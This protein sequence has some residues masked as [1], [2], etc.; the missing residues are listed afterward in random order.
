ME[1]PRSRQTNWLQILIV[2]LLILGVF[3]RFA[4]LDY[5]VYWHDEVYTSIRAAGYTR[6]EIDRELFQNRII[7]AK[8]LQKFQRLKPG[9]TTTDTI[10]S[11]ATED[12]QHP[13]LYFLM[14][15]FWMQLFGSSLTA[16]RSLP[17]LLSL[18]GLPLMYG[19]GLELF[20]SRLVAIL[21]TTLL[22]LSPFDILFAQTARQYSLLTVTVIGS[23]FLL[24]RALRLQTWQNWVLY[25]FCS[26][27]GLYTHPI[28]G[29]TLIAQGAYVLVLSLPFSF[30][31]SW[32]KSLLPHPSPLLTKAPVAKGRKL[33]PPLLRGVRGV[34]QA[35]SFP[36]SEILKLN[37]F[38]R[39]SD[40]FWY[41]LLATIGTLFLYSP[42][43][44][45]IT[46][47][48]QRLSATTNW[49]KVSPGR[50]HLIKLWILNFTSLF[51]DLDFGLESIWSYL[52]RLPV[53]ILIVVAIYTV[54]RQT[55][56][57]IGLFILTAIFVPFLIL[58]L[59]DVLFGGKRS[60]I[61]RYLMSCYPG[62]Q[63]VVAYLLANKLLLEQWLWRG[64]AVVLITGSI[65]S[66]TVSGFSD[67]WWS[68]GLSYFNA[69][70]ARIINRDEMNAIQANPPLVLS[71]IGDDFT[72]TGDLISLSYLLHDNV[73]LLLLNNP[74][75]L[76]ILPSYSKSFVF[77]PSKQLCQALEDKQVSLEQ[78]SILGRL[79]RIQPK[80][81]GRSPT[82]QLLKCS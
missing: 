3:F 27:V 36:K 53:F 74:P 82:N 23:N 37:N 34:L 42:W 69:E 63:L 18:L 75:N 13:P 79:W 11:L 10:S 52:L 31:S 32:S 44:I 7:P 81:S 76:E 49:T 15:R 56:R 14:A 48:Y 9:S 61:S 28:F 60:T 67:I 22:A 40:Q 59:P 64:V 70:V 39:L 29:L 5:K 24:L 57:T 72:N 17:A 19:L 4:N 38:W 26:A 21:A 33:V 55:T 50:L 62:V 73:Q 16:S 25:S 45:V 8:E 47:N 71:D 2:V 43:L 80:G 58:A 20:G 68:K 78:A 1:K 35:L 65:A 66:C 12:P 41:Y 30:L 46:S 51:L 54:C 77:R 6:Q